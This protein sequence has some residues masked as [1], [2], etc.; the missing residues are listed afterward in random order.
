MTKEQLTKEFR[1]YLAHE[2]T[3]IESKKIIDFLVN[4]FSELANEYTLSVLK[5]EIP[6][7]IIEG[8]GKH[9][10]NSSLDSAIK[11]YIENHIENKF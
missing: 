11:F 8:T 2:E 1:Y 7:A 9:P 10:N 3:G 4:K 5:S 6:K